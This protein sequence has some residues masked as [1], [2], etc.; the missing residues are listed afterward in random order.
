M[1]TRL[2]ILLPLVAAKLYGSA[3]ALPQDDAPAPHWPWWLRI[4]AVIGAL[5][6]IQIVAHSMRKGAG[7]SPPRSGQDQNQ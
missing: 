4:L 7:G 6:F 5:A 2:A 3:L 1:R